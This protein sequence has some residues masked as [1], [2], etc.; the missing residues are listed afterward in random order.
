MDGS[1]LLAV[2]RLRQAQVDGVLDRFFSL[3][4]DEPLSIADAVLGRVK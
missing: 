2:D 3:A 4:N 1:G